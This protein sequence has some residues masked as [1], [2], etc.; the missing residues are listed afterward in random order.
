LFG[1]ATSDIKDADEWMKVVDRVGIVSRRAVLL[2]GL[3]VVQNLAMPYT[4]EVEPPST[5]VRERAVALAVD[6]G[7]PQ[8]TFDRPIAELDPANLVLTRLARALALDPSVVF[9][10]HPTASVARADIAG[11]AARCRAV[12][13]RRHIATVALTADRE[14]AAA[15]ATRVLQWDPASGRLTSGGWLSRF[16]RS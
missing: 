2:D 14:F 11:L 13:S 4:L 1:R 10:E 16:K 5:D 7:L 9:L 12:T 6:A 3:T 8:A 15:A